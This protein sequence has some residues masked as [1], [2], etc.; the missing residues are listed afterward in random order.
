MKPVAALVLF[1]LLAAGCGGD[2]DLNARFEAERAL[3]KAN[4]EV[5]RLSIRPELVTEATWRHAVAMFAAIPTRYPAR[6]TGTTSEELRGVHAYALLAAA[7]IYGSLGDSVAML[8]TYARIEADYEDLPT[9]SGQVAFARGRVAE[10]R[11]DWKGALS[12][13]ETTLARVARRSGDPGVAGAVLELPLRMSRIKVVSARDSSMAFRQEAYRDA[14]RTYQ[15][16]VATADT[17]TAL[18]A[19]AYLA[20]VA[21]DNG[22]WTGA[23]R[24]LS[25]LETLLAGM[26]PPRKD[27]A[28]VRYSLAQLQQRSKASPETIQA[29]LRSLITTYPESPFAVQSRIALAYS[30]AQAGHLEEALPPLEEV[31]KAKNA[32]EDLAGQ[33][34]LLRAQILD[35]SGR[36]TEAQQILHA[37]P[38]DHPLTESALLAPIEIVRHYERLGDEAGA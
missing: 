26:N 3:W 10:S 17:L 1:V 5:Q 30:L 6:G 8:D 7:R 2:T 20:D 32:P 12:A 33:A 15:D 18:D 9:V 38:V 29:T 19:R 14:E 16:L 4:A 34:L 36:W 13:Y 25:E 21:A 37:I 24:Y 11:G 23:A 31:A 22:D 27:P 28:S 35:R